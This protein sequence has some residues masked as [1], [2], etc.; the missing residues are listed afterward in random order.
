MFLVLLYFYV[1]CDCIEIYKAVVHISLQSGALS[2]TVSIVKEEPEA[3]RSV[4]VP[5]NTHRG[6]SLEKKPLEYI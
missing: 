2:G 6:I 5:Y 1:P 3:N 4:D